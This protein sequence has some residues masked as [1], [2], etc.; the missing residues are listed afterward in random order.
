MAAVSGLLLATAV[1]AVWNEPVRS[2]EVQYNGLARAYVEGSREI[3]ANGTQSPLQIYVITMPDRREHVDAMLK[4]IGLDSVAHVFPAVM[5]T[6]LDWDNLVAN[7]EVHHD[8]DLTLGEVACTLSHRAVMKEFLNTTSEYALVFED[9][10]IA[11][12][13]FTELLEERR[14][15]KENYTSLHLLE[16]LAATSKK[17]GWH[18]LNLGR[19]WDKCIKQ[20]FIQDFSSKV[21]LVKS[22]R[23]LCTEAYIFTRDAARVHLKHTR[24]IRD[25]EDRARISFPNF[26]YFSTNPRIF[27]QLDGKPGASINGIT[28]QPECISYQS[29]EDRKRNAIRNREREKMV[30]K[31]K[32][33]RR[34][35]L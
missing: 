25:A 30:A 26:E 7:G 17:V 31:L 27:N 29:K 14:E 4:S 19:C 28:N 34:K 10:A 3:R 22:R 2:V 23:S 8:S 13:I 33:E 35:K 21:Q 18:G 16:E 15:G 6:K 32:A 9:D 5:K 11:P 1:S 20:E 12:D 24:P